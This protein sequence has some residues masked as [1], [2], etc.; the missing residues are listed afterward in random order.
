VASAAISEDWK[1]QKSPSVLTSRTEG[2]PSPQSLFARFL[3]NGVTLYAE[4][5]LL[6]HIRSRTTQLYA[7]LAPKTLLDATEV[8]SE[9]IGGGT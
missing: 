2:T 5:G 4:Q 7:H 9:V 6:G 3:V 8:I 1:A